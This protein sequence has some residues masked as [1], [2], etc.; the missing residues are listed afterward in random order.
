MNHTS[1]SSYLLSVEVD[2]F[3]F[4]TF[5]FYETL[6]LVDSILSFI[7]GGFNLILLGFLI[8]VKWKDFDV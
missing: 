3:D 2:F 5:G 7:S 8:G 4:V 1:K 6:K